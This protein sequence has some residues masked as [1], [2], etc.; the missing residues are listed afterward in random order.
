MLYIHISFN[1][2]TFGLGIQQYADDTQLYVSLTLTDMHVR[3]SQ[4]SNCCLFTI[5]QRVSDFVIS[6]GF[7]S[8]SEYSSKSLHLR[9]RP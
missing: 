8:T 9:I 1:A 4:L 3:Q 6:T 2:D 5:F 7:L